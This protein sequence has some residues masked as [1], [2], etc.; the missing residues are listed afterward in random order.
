LEESDPSGLLLPSHIVDG[1]QIRLELYRLSAMFL[2]SDTIATTVLADIE[3]GRA[4][5]SEFRFMRTLTEDHFYNEMSRILIYT[6]IQCRIFA[7]WK[8]QTDNPAWGKTCGEL[9][10]AIAK[11]VP[12]GQGPLGGRIVPLTVKEAFNKI[13]HA[14]VMN[15]DV[16]D[17]E[18]CQAWAPKAKV[19]PWIYL[20]GR[21]NG[22]PWRETLNI[23]DYIGWVNFA[24]PRGG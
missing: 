9:E 11:D 12:L 3:A 17:A 24:I 21:Q 18:T 20:Y 5:S 2:S 6:A 8:T 23:I 22:R 7:G 1:A 15:A 10:K 13:I 16:E 4:G 19:N 14:E